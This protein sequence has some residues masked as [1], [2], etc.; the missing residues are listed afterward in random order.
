LRVEAVLGAWLGAVGINVLLSAFWIWRRSALT[1][2]SWAVVRDGWGRS[3]VRGLRAL[4]AISLTLVL[5]RTD[6]YMLGPMLGARAVGQISV[7]ATLAEYLWYVPSILSSM[8]FAAV[9]ASRGPATVAQLGRAFRTVIVALVPITL[10]LVVVGHKLV[11]LIYGAAYDDAGMLLVLLAPGMLAISLHLVIDS[12]FT[13]SGFP[14]ITYVSAGAAVLL[15]VGLNLVVVPRR[16]I[17]GA[18]VTTSLVYVS[19]LAAKVVAFRQAT[20]APLALLFRVSWSDVT[21][22]VRTARAWVRRLGQAPA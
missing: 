10:A 3:L 2:F 20:G 13:G 5:V 21:R 14:P 8:M 15:K 7:A 22:N 18:A 1:T 9:A 17:E 12:Y 19:L 6:V 11:P 16:G 4:L